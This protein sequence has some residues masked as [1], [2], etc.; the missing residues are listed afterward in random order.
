MAG[1]GFELKRIMRHETF[2]SEFTA[3]L[4]S[5]MISSGPWLMSILCLAV[6]GI[7]RG[8]EN[9]KAH[10]I[11]R[12]T[13]VYTYASS[14]I[15]SGIIQLVC[16][17]YLADQLYEQKIDNVLKTF[18]TCTVFILT[19]G[20]LLSVL[21]YWYF[22]I[23]ILHKCL[24]VLL[25]LV[26]NMIWLSMIFLSA[27]KD[28]HSVVFSFAIGGIVSI[29]LVFKLGAV[30]GLE[31][32]LLGYLIGQA[33]TLFWL[34]ARLLAEFP[35]S[36][37]WDK[38]LLSYFKKY[39]DLACIGFCF[40][41]GIWVDKFVFWTAADSN[42]IVPYFRT[43][44]LYDSPLFFSY[45]TIVPTLAMFM[46]KIETSFYDHYRKYFSKVIGK[47]D[48]ANIL[49][50]KNMMVTTLKE[51]IREIFIIQGAVTIMCIVFT[52]EII[53][54]LNFSALQAPIFRVTL[55]G[56]FLNILLVINVI[57]LFYFD[58][59][60]SV[61]L[62]TMVFLFCNFGFSL[63]TTKLGIQYYGYGYTYCCLFSLL[64]AFQRLDSNM[65]NLEFIT[66]T[67]QP[68]A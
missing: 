54:A 53:E 18:Y 17:R 41:L 40:N 65:K 21:G 44:N 7:F 6:L 33:I 29:V 9:A 66:F 20:T 36:Q 5:A 56:A 43:H 67:S 48:M 8:G 63:L 68:V 58:Q 61:L 51:S 49:E 2:L 60:K 12:S 16:T 19:G 64:T 59:R 35:A 13:V 23:S 3:Y 14:L 28:Y 4:Y 11:F 50:E 37:F 15:Y 32:D 39:W 55:I 30:F 1:I 45:L 46:L 34:M 25:F 26:I 57:I 10:E 24:G 31:G 38:G 22:E 52:P 27:V 62:V 47:K 42:V